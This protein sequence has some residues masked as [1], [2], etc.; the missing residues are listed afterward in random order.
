MNFSAPIWSE[1]QP[2]PYARP[3]GE[4][5]R[6]DVAVVGGGLT[7]LSAAHHLLARRPGL[8]LVVLEAERIGEG[9]SGRTTGI[10]GPGVGQNFASLLRRV[11]PERASALYR[12]TLRAVEYVR[13]LVGREGIDCDL[14]MTGQLIVARSRGGRA[15]LDALSELLRKFELPC[16]RLDDGALAERIRLEPARANGHAGR[17]PAALRLPV[18]GI[19]HPVRLLAGLAERVT[20]RG[21]TVFEGA[22]VSGI[23]PGAPTRLE[24]NGGGEV[25]ADEVVIA[26]AGYTPGLGLLQ[27]RVLPVHL[28]VLSTEPISESQLSLIG[29]T[30]REAVL[31]DRRLFNYFRLTRDNRLV[32]GGGTPRYHWRGRTDEDKSEAGAALERLVEEMGRTFPAG[33]GLRVARGWTGVIAYVLD[34]LPS[35]HYSR[36]RG[37]VLHAVG[38][39]GHGVA[40]S[41]AAGD[42]IAS[43]MCGDDVDET[44]PWF[45]ESPPLIP[46]EPVRWA[47]FRAGVKMMSL[48]DHV[49]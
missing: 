12:A 4:T 3:A 45:R 39:C 26:T 36:G 20:A 40:L 43:L 2:P 1:A 42:W 48:L 44:L 25:L 19:V 30:G 7:G 9:A 13:T 14:E 8:R 22:R 17:G 34:A 47:G 11:G 49:A 5:I 46:F 31:D 10:L 16:E 35:I 24:L 15:R 38:W 32:F 21:G 41:V 33:M 37:S 23:T 18:A 27:G 28:Q 29:W 6:A